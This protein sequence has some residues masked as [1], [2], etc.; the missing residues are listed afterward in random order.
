MRV[1]QSVEA[2]LGW[3]CW[4]RWH[5]ARARWHHYQRRARAEPLPLHTVVARQQQR[6]RHAKPLSP[7]RTV[8]AL[9]AGVSAPEETDVVW[10][11][12]EA[13]L[14]PAERV[15][16]P[17]KYERRLVLEALVYLMHSDCGWQHLPARFPPWPTVY[18][19]LRQWRKTGIW[20]K[21][22]A[23]IDQPHPTSELQL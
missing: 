7:P 12:L 15:G 1:E 20:E 5:Q 2:L 14:P 22:W 4:R 11:R 18:A 19:Q 9:P 3:S 21:I 10:R 23:G 6:R 8:V 13:L 16:R 17:Y